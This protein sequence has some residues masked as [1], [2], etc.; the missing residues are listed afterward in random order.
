[1]KVNKIDTAILKTLTYSDVFASPLNLSDLH[2]YLYKYVVDK[3]T[4]Q[5]VLQNTSWVK[6]IGTYYVLA[7]R[8]SL[9]KTYR[10]NVKESKRKTVIA[11]RI[12]S[13][14][15]L[16][17]TIRMIGI[18]GSV[19]AE[20]ATKG[21]DIDLFII[22]RHHSLWITRF[23]ATMVVTI[24][25]KKRAVKSELA[26]DTICMNMWMSEDNLLLPKKN[27][28][29]AREVLQLKVVYDSCHT[30]ASFLHANNWIYTYFPNTSQIFNFKKKSFPSFSFF[31]FINFFAYSIQR[32]YMKNKITS[33]IVDTNFAAFH[34]RDISKVVLQMY[35]NRVKVYGKS[36]NVGSSLSVK[37]RNIT[38][39][40]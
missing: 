14:L 37:K 15:R 8:E 10:V 34:P 11:K 29:V 21:A 20:N 2:R 27:I 25:R 18:S 4:L 22:T 6:K 3:K 30:Y 12:V 39:G 28:F 32:I 40:S 9:V 33:E 19:A 5:L 7:G 1:M 13:I 36:L 24:L 23:L 31:S 17:P 35:R 38:P 26:P 16:I